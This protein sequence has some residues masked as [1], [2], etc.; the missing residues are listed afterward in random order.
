MASPP[1]PRIQAPPR[2]LVVGAI[3]T[4]TFTYVNVLKLKSAIKCHYVMLL[5]FPHFVSVF[6]SFKSILI[7]LGNSPQ[8]FHHL[9]QGR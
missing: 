8:V 3:E 9:N 2:A 7:F 5:Q 6:N 1:P 4:G